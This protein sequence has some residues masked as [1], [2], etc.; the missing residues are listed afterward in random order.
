M[1]YAFFL[2]GFVI[3]FSIAAPVG[4]IGILCIRRSLNHGPRAGFV[5]G[6]GAATADAVYGS[7][8]AFGLAAFAEFLVG[9]R[10]WLQL[11][12]GI[13]LCGLG[14]RSW[15]KSHLPESAAPTEGSLAAAYVSTLFVT[16]SNPMTI[17]S[18]AAVFAGFGL[19]NNPSTATAATLV[20][21][22][23]LGSAIW[24][25]ILSQG[26]GFL[27]TQW[28]G[29]CVKFIDRASACIM[30]GFGLASIWAAFRQWH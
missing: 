10:F 13:F 25:L 18:F 17:L 20:A 12:G 23:F 27:R 28:T 30:G 22:V 29:L 19:A 2:K 21:G 15:W 26:I 9:Q 11:V 3:G 24:W 6:A 4:P 1:P 16:L 5:T 14:M 8:A 7:I